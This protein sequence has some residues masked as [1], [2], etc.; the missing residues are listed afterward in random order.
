MKTQLNSAT[1][2]SSAPLPYPGEANLADLESRLPEPELRLK[3][4]DRRWARVVFSSPSRGFE[5]AQN[6]GCNI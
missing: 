6:Q 2:T 4:P 5:D 1:P 3:V